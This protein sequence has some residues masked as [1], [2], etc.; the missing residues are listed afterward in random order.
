VILAQNAGA[1]QY[2]NGAPTGRMK[3][4]VPP[5]HQSGPAKLNRKSNLA[6]DI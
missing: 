1:D 3:G 5:A 4:S 6:F 2:R